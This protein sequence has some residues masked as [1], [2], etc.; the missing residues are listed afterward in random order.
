MENLNGNIQVTR[1][2]I[3]ERLYL[4][5]VINKCIRSYTNVLKKYVP[6]LFDDFKQEL[7]II[8]LEKG[9]DALWEM[10]GRGQLIGFV[11]QTV[12]RI[13]M[14]PRN[15]IWKNY[16]PDDRASE[17]EYDFES[18]Y[19]KRFGGEWDDEL[20]IREE[21]EKQEDVDL[22]EFR[23]RIQQLDEKTG[24]PFYRCV[25]ELVSVYGT[26]REVAR[27]TGIHYSAISRAMKRVKEE[28]Q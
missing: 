4:S 6:T 27:L 15:V 21:Q 26:Q 13:A 17:W 9:K 14:Q 12:A 3:I 1:E 18:I 11:V 19:Q 10:E 23:E 24:S 25:A 8:L 2:N 5:P 22:D 28:L 20:K 16:M 7:F